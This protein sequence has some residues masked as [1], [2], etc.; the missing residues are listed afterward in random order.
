MHLRATVPASRINDDLEFS[1]H[2][3][4]TLLQ[5]QHRFLSR[6]GRNDIIKPQ[7]TDE[8]TTFEVDYLAGAFVYVITETMMQYPCV[9]V[10]EK[11]WKAMLCPVPFLMLGT[12]NTLAWL[13]DQGF[14]TFGEW[15][16]ESYDIMPRAA[17]RIEAVV[18]ELG[19]LS[20][21]TAAQ[22]ID[23]RQQMQPV[24]QH[25]LANLRDMRSREL[26]KIQSML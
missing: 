17:D 23:L 13:R 11:T 15:W 19:E 16:D 14:Q 12:A 10:T 20:K 22:L 4:Q 2:Q 1:A 6:T 5:H 9:Y 21:L 8:C 25:N 7:L 26:A 24:L 18:H 3:W